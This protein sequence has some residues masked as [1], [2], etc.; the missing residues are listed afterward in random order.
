MSYFIIGDIHGCYYTFEQ[1]LQHWDSTTEILISV[2]DLIDRGN[3]SAKVVQKCM[4]LSEN[5]P[6]TL[7]LK[8]N[9]EVEMIRHF[10][11]GYNKMWVDYCGLETLEDFELSNVDIDK[12]LNWVEAMPLKFEADRLLVTHAGLA[13]VPEPYN[14]NSDLGVVWNR[15]PLMNI[16]KLQVHGHTPLKS[17]H[18][19]YND[20]SNS[21][22]IDTGAVYGYGL[23]GLKVDNNGSVT[24]KIFVK[25]DP[26]DILPDLIEFS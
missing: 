26:R 18:P 10:R 16:G 12:L 20:T 11:I 14:E 6:N 8:G 1:M 15:A 23:T 5:Y 19:H 13:D 3:Y 22:N 17:D 25:V 9:H 24:E 2:G 21:W 7:F 4:E